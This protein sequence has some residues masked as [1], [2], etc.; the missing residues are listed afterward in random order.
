MLTDAKIRKIKPDTNKKTPSKYSD[1]NGL[2]LHVFPTGRM[3]WIYAYRFQNKQRSLTLGSYPDV[4]LADARIK[5]T[6][7]RKI[8]NN[9][10]DPNQAKKNNRIQLDGENSFR[11]VALEWHSKK[12]ETWAVS[13]VKKIRTRLDK[14]ILPY[15]GDMEIST[16]EAPDLLAVIKRI[17]GRS[18]DTAKRAL[19]ECGAIFRYGMALGKNKHDPSQA[20]T[21][22]LLPIKQNHFAALT[23]PA[24]V[25]GLLRAIDGFTGSF[26]VKCALQLAP[27]FFVRIGELRTAKWNDIDLEAAEWRYFITKT[28]QNHIVP[29][30]TQAIA[31]LK[32]LQQLTGQYEHVFIGGRDPKHPMSD[33]AINAALRRMGFS[34][35]D[36]IT[37][38]GFRAMARTILHEQLGYERD[39]IEH[40]L[41][42]A[43]PDSLGTAYNR[44]K[45]LKQR[46]EMMQHWA[47]YLNDLKQDVIQFPKNKRA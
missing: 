17:E 44:T 8:L 7:A 19:Q 22:L 27:L 28:K 11:Y 47:D 24:Q 21:G 23:E 6:E 35:K 4:S 31:I 9:G 13:T 1:T 18:P 29:L 45:F 25:G 38:H 40:Q 10:I 3:T 20:L 30:S 5:A 2:Q 36:E 12:A 14:D 43:V 15:I 42:H 46:R 39:V 26:V 37:G 33:A 16:I 34:T 32:D 41:A